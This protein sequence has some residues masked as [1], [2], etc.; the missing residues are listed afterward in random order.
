MFKIIKF[1]LGILGLILSSSVTGLIIFI[2][3]KL[4][5]KINEIF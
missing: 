3:I 4:V 5:L 2:I 1:I